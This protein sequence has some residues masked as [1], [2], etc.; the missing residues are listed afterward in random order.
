MKKSLILLVIAAGAA[1]VSGCGSTS[2]MKPV[3]GADIRS[4]QKY[5]RVCVLAIGNKTSSQPEAGSEYM[6]SQGRRFADLI[7]LEVEKKAVFEKVAHVAAPQPGSLVI[8]G[9]ITRCVEGS[10]AM[11]L[12]VG[13]GAGS[14]Y[15]DATVQFA[16]A[17]TG[18]QLGEI[19]VDKNSWV[20]GGGIAS[21]QTVEE[22]MEGAAKKIA[23]QA[24]RAKNGAVA[25]LKR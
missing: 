7:A 5:N 17:D 10:A 2:N 23:E 1:L 13:L 24:A 3:A 25:G 16:D 15:F 12:L 4:L 8:Q 22:F 21:T 14:S 9:D 6:Q 18:Q 11:R 19:T 20:L